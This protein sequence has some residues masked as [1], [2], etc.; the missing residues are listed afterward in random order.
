MI[1][2]QRILRVCGSLW[3]KRLSACASAYVCP[4]YV[5]RWESRIPVCFLRNGEKLRHGGRTVR[6]LWALNIIAKKFISGKRPLWRR[7]DEREYIYFFSV[8]LFLSD[9][10]PL[11]TYD[12][13]TRVNEHSY[14][15][16]RMS[17]EVQGNHLKEKLKT[18]KLVGNPPSAMLGNRLL[19]CY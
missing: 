2:Q 7:K 16:I 18:N 5:N 9:S 15:K 11:P 13:S 6:K 3:E 12:P 19:L 4:P 17:R 1:S 10:I 8:P 14:V